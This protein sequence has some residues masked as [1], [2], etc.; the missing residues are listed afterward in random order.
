MCVARFK[1]KHISNKLLPLYL[2]T[3]GSDHVRNIVFLREG[4]YFTVENKTETLTIKRKCYY[5]RYKIC[6]N[7]RTVTLH[8]VLIQKR[9]SKYKT[10]GYVSTVYWPIFCEGLS[11]VYGVTPQQLSFRISPSLVPESL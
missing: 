1:E 4:G 8:K 5:K 7:W 10:S 6:S 9:N 11:R 3:R 2:T